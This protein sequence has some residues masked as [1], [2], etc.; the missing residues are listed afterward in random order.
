MASGV[1]R[2]ASGLAA[3]P[4]AVLICV[5][6]AVMWIGV[7]V[8][9]FW[10]AGELTTTATGFLFFV[11]GA[12]PAAMV[13]LGFAL[14][15]VNVV[16]ESLRP[17]KRPAGAPR[18]AWSAGSTDERRSL[19]RAREGHSLLDIAMATSVVVAI[20]LMLVWFFFF[21]EQMLAPMQ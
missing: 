6:S 11:L 1:T 10:L 5:G 17:P 13:A 12:I 9:G 2:E 21:A 20:V 18:A 14:H 15:R 4:L 19:R 16:Y 3:A 7:P 8:G